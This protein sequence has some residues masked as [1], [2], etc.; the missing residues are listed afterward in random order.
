MCLI[1]I[2]GITLEPETPL[3]KVISFAGSRRDPAF[4]FQPNLPNQDFRIPVGEWIRAERTASIMVSVREALPGDCNRYLFAR[5]KE[6]RGFHCFEEREQA[7]AF[8]RAHRGRS[9]L[10]EACFSIVKV[11]G[12]GTFT[13]GEDDTEIPCV[14]VEEMILKNEDLAPKVS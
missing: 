14:A 3:W 7:E 2:T 12:R 1:K 8:V 11:T 6:Y 10:L 13:R 5:S 4:P 9:M